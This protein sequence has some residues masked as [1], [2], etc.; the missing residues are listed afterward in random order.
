MVVKNILKTVL[1]F[2]IGII[3]FFAF[4][5]LFMPKKNLLKYGFYKTSLFE[6]L[7]ENSKSIDVIVVGDSL[8]YSSI[9][10]MKIYGDYGYT[11]F[12]CAE[13]AQIIS[14][15][16]E[17]YKVSVESQKPKIVFIE[18]NMLFRDSSKKP[19]YNRYLKIFKNSTPLFKYHNN[20]KKILF[21]NLGL[22]NKDKGYIFSNKIK[23]SKNFDYMAKNKRKYN[24]SQV[25]IDYF[26]KMLDIANKNNIKVVLL[27]LP[28]QK[29]WN[30][31]KH[32]KI[33]K[34]AKDYQLDYLNLNLID[35]INI[36]WNKDTKDRGD[37]LNSYGS[38]KVSKYIGKYLKDTNILKSHKKDKKYKDWNTLYKL[39]AK[40]SDN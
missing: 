24:I 15:A 25:N 14:D 1:F 21:S 9:S 7:G 26:E 38:K 40:N 27:G 13:P 12:N 10:P 32:K 37:H 5:Y 35:D 30:N 20:W 29:S 8:V 33:L 4:S 11:V 2:V 3:L 34:L 28:S 39:Y 36:D 19:W 16:Y 23:P 17:Y 6:I 18:A 22:K 31:D